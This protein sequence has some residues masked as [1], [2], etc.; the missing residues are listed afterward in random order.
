MV[1]IIA[2]RFGGS[3]A[4]NDD[5]AP[6]AST[7]AISLAGR[8]IGHDYGHARMSKDKGCDDRGCRMAYDIVPCKDGWCGIA[9]NTD[10]SCGATG[11]HLTSD[12]ESGRTV[13]KGTLELA[14]GAAPYVVQ[15]W[16]DIDTATQAPS[17]H[18]LGNT[19]TEFLLF[20]RSF[21]MDARMART[22]DAECALP[23]TTS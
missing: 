17:L 5:R 4:A 6:A 9:L 14:K 2:V 22:G 10:N 12:T 15:A 16:H 1:S 23:K 7:T 19:G 11:L 8:W 18:I 13:F 20:R 3:A 21:P